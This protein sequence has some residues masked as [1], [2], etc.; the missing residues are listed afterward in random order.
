MKYSEAEKFINQ[1]F[2][3]KLSA[4]LH[5]HN[6]DHTKDVVNA[7]MR[8][9]AGESIRDEYELMRLKTAALFH[10]AGYTV[11]Y[12][13]HE[14]EGCFIARK[15]LPDFNYSEEDIEEICNMIMAT[16]MP[17]KPENILE[18][19]L[20]DADLDY[21]GREDFDTIS[22]KLF[23]E[24]LLRGKV[25]DTEQWNKLQTEFLKSHRYW[26]HSSRNLREAKKQEHLKRIQSS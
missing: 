8:I 9:A 4:D 11:S 7:A 6:L 13:D 1:L 3:E 21:L 12:A 18:K 16:K 23:E 20:C 24:W 15:H 26:T 5:F 2:S 22:T 25:S 19:I 10:D 17:Q 14:N